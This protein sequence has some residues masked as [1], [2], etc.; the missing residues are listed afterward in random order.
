MSDNFEQSRKIAKKLRKLFFG[1]FKILSHFRRGRGLF[2]KNFPARAGILDIG[3]PAP[4]GDPGAGF[5]SS[6][7]D[8]F[9]TE[10]P[11]ERLVKKLQPKHREAVPHVLR[12]LPA[13]EWPEHR[14]PPAL[15]RVPGAPAGRRVSISPGLFQQVALVTSP[16]VKL[17]HYDLPRSTSTRACR[18][19]P[20]LPSA[21]TSCPTR[22]CT[23]GWSTACPWTPRVMAHAAGG[24]STA[25]TA[26]RRA[27]QP[28]WTKSAEYVDSESHGLCSRTS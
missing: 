27:A 7:G 26:A 16:I 4:Q 3:T 14:D 12:V 22:P 23:S 9:A 21:S 18:G 24:S 2:Q 11:R 17:Q 6:L 8:R 25:P 28:A 19:R 20:S 1:F 5:S 10:G 13:P 15:R